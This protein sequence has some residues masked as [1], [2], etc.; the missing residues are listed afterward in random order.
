MIKPYLIGVSLCALAT[1]AFAEGTLKPGHVLG[2]GSSTERTG[3]D[4]PII[5]ILQQSGSGLGTGVGTALANAI[6]AT[7]GV[8]TYGLI[9]TSG[10]T[11]P[12][13]NS[14]NLFSGTLRLSA[15]PALTQSW[16]GVTT[17]L[18]AL[19]MDLTAARASGGEVAAIIRMTSGL[20][21]SVLG[22]DYKVALG[23]EMTMNPGSADG[24]AFNAVNTINA[25]VGTR[26]GQAIE[27]DLNNFN[28]DYPL[29]NQGGYLG[30]TA[31]GINIATGNNLFPA[32]SG[33]YMGT[34]TASGFAWHAG[35]YMYGA[36]LIK[37]YDVY[38]NTS[39]AS[40][41]FDEGSK[42]TGI[43][44][45]GGTYS[46]N[47]YQSP[48]VAIGG[49]G[50]AQFV[51]LIV[52]GGS[53]HAAALWT[54]SN[55]LEVQAGPAGIAFPN[56]TNSVNLALLTNAG[57]LTIYNSASVGAGGISTTGAV[58][59]SYGTLGTPGSINPTNGYYN[60]QSKIFGT[61]GGGGSSAFSGSMNAE[62]HLSAG[63]GGLALGV[64]G[65]AFDDGTWSS[66]GS[67][68]AGAVGVW[69]Q[70][71]SSQGGN[72]FGIEAQATANT[73]VPT[74]ILG[75]EID[76]TN[77]VNATPLKYGLAIND[78]GTGS[79]TGTLTVATGGTVANDAAIFLQVTSGGSVWGL[80]N[81]ILSIK[82]PGGNQPVRTTGTIWREGGFTTTAGI[83]W[84]DTFFSGD[85]VNISNAFKVKGTGNVT[86]ID[87]TIFEGFY[88][89]NGVFYAAELIGA[90]ATNDGGTLLLKKAGTTTV[91][92]SG[93]TSSPISYFNAAGGTVCIGMTS[94][95]AALTVTGGIQAIVRL[96]SALT[97]CNAGA[98]GTEEPVS[99]ATSA[100]FNAA[101]VGSG[102]N[103]IRAYCNG[104]AWVV[105]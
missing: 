26:Q 41:I 21:G 85:A 90:D 7:G 80:D 40:L 74:A 54:A 36:T 49:T 15:T 60:L 9:G 10:A 105:H 16:S 1:S 81:Q 43:N 28:K 39:A 27:A 18:T 78:N 33:I 61:V 70:G 77:N 71:Q 4:T 38:S 17:N 55:Y 30:R 97:T 89:N 13:N 96:V 29:P 86:V 23:T 68:V 72:I 83:D 5:T 100:T 99:D 47:A 59:T 67:S 12:L 64:I 2:N 95:S 65:Q 79:V 20:G 37:D 87:N 24:Y 56:A 94:C 46:G 102:S 98:E 52:S 84:H 3:T 73:T 57:D 88:L 44:L 93:A 31:L 62:S 75:E 69:G 34:A 51:E 101:V 11:V 42:I 8:L 91:Q 14:N 76:V 32:S 19:A 82:Q 35:L 6:N 25:S 50:I 104:S 58:S 53:A 92:I 48:G 63:V 45:A 66:G 103:H 22:S